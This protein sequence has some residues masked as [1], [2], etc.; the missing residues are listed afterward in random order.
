MC[1]ILTD[2]ACVQQS[3][4]LCVRI[5]SA[6]HL[7]G[8]LPRWPMCHMQKCFLTTRTTMTFKLSCF[9]CQMCADKFPQLVASTPSLSLQHT[10]VSHPYTKHGCKTNSDVIQM[11]LFG[12]GSRIGHPDVCAHAVHDTIALHSHNNVAAC[13]PQWQQNA[14]PFA[15]KLTTAVELQ[16]RPSM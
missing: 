12:C 9:P 1:T 3:R 11:V 14:I 4:V 13:K 7:S 6:L 16:T 15:P 2:L 10:R 8:N 5:C